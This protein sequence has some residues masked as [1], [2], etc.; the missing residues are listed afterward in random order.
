MF[1]IVCAPEMFQKVMEQILAGCEGCFNYMDD[2]IIYGETMEQLNERVEKVLQKLKEYNVMLNYEKCIFGAK[3]LVFLGHTLSADGIKPTHDKIKA[4]KDFRQPTCAEEVR[5]FLGFVNFVG[6]YIPNLATITEPLRNLTRKDT[7]YSWDINQRTAFEKLKN[8]LSSNLVL[9][10]YN[11]HDRTQV[12]ADA[13]PVALGAVLIQFNEKGCPRVISYASKSLSD[14]EKRYCQTE[15]E[16]LAL[17]WAVER[18]HFYL[19]GRSFELITDHKALEVIFSPTS[20]PCAR[21]ERWVLRLQSYKFDVI[22]KPGKNNIADPLSRLVISDP[23]HA[24]FDYGTEEHVNRITELAAPIAIKICEIQCASKEDE[25]IREV[26]TGLDTQNWSNKAV[27]FRM[28]ETELCFSGDILLRGNRIVIPEKLRARTIE[29]AHGGHPGMTK[30]EQRL[31]AKVWWPKIDI[32]VENY[33]KKCHGCT[34]VMAPPPPEPMKRTELPNK[35]W[36]FVAID[37][38]GPLPSGHYL[39]VIVDYFSRFFE[40]EI[41]KKIDTAEAI[42]RLRTIFARFGFPESLKADNGPQFKSEDFQNYCIENNIKFVRTTPYWPREN[43][44]VE[45]QNKSILK[46]LIISQNQNQNWKQDMLEFLHMYRSTPHSI[47]MKTPSEL[48][49]G[50]TIRDKLPNIEQPSEV[51]ESLKDHDKEKKEM[52]KQY[53]DGKRNAKT[54]ELKVG[55]VVWLKRLMKTNKLS[56][57]FDPEPYVIIERMGSELLVE[58]PETKAKYRR[59]VAHATLAPPAPEA[60]NKELPISTSDE[61]TLDG[62]IPREKSQER[63]APSMKFKEPRPKRACARP[64]RLN[65]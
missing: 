3:E 39:F 50:R 42:H 60:A 14:T 17:V 26:K 2:I 8:H 35:P 56:P 63:E 22:Y 30:M 4:I 20:K 43:G 57:T 51:D 31:R 6:Q 9:G 46:R 47:T 38:M 61:E 13:S 49:F 12:Y 54:S 41:M 62:N 7:Q 29:L 45:R 18:F 15:K 34:M 58:D 25:T 37:F 1:G 53:S 40:I 44:E 65:N 48:M 32:D 33:V 24:C 36:Q 10:Y 23:P 5:S 27:P 64:A 16:A 59:N 55:D 28:F 21:I 52:G 11:V 19:F